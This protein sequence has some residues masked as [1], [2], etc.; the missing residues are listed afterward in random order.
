MTNRQAFKA[1]NRDIENL[2]RQ[3]KINAEHNPE[4]VS[5]TYCAAIDGLPKKFQHYID[6]TESEHW[7]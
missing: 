1:L 6:L 2:C 4:Q 5:E 7:N 3:A